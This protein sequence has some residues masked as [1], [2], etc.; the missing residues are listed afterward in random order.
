M[1]T[2]QQAAESPAGQQAPERPAGQPAADSPAGQ[3]AA[4][5]PAGQQAAGSQSGRQAAPGRRRRGPAPRHTRREVVRAAV[6]IADAEGLDAVTIR[7]VAG[8]LGTGVMSLYSYVPDKQTLVYDMA[9]EVS[10]ELDLPEPSG[11]WRADIHLLAARQR[12]VVR[13]HPWMIEAAT[14]LQ[15]LGPA[16]LAVMEWVLDVL[17]PT[18]LSMRAQLE[19]FGL[20]NG[21]VI[22]MVRTELT[23]QAAGAADP[24]QAAR[25]AE[26]LATGRY[27]RFAAAIAQQGPPPAD[28][29]ADLVGQFE[30][31]L[32]RILDG[33]VHPD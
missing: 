24:A 21:F 32:D 25:L 18:G 3:Q 6:A 7:A 26:L 16:I 10:G 23:G 5:R 2:G 15:P 13:R 12:E 30:R 17:E 28:P 4:E 8:R 20:V 27:P 33:L 9:E 14:H 31:L 22:G 19:T 11:D 29:T 1:P